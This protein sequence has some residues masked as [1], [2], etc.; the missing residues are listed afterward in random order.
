MHWAAHISYEGGKAVEVRWFDCGFARSSLCLLPESPTTNF[1]YTRPEDHRDPVPADIRFL[2]AC[3]VRPPD[4]R[5]ELRV[6]DRRPE[7][8]PAVES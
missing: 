3:G 7:G 2:Q 8:I 6:L 5:D 4:V 1:A